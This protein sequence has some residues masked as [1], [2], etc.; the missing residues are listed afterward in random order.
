MQPDAR[1]AYN[2]NFKKQT[3]VDKDYMVCTSLVRI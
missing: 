3:V 2:R 1:K